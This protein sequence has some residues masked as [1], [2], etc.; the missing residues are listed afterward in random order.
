MFPGGTTS[1]GAWDAT[2]EFW[3]RWSSTLTYS[4]LWR[5]AVVR[6]ALAM[7]MVVFAP[8]GAPSRRRR[9]PRCRRSSAGLAIGTTV[10]AG[11]ATRRSRIEALLNLGCLA[12][13]RA[14]FWWFMHATRLTRPRIRVFH[15]LDGGGRAPERPF[16]AGRLPWLAAGARRQRRRKPAA[17][18]C[19]QHSPR[20]GMVVRRRR[21]GTGPGHG[22]RARRR[23]R[24]RLR[25]LAAAGPWDMEVRVA[26]SQ[27]I[28]SKVMSWVVLDRALRLTDA[29]Y[30]SRR[31][32][33]R[34]RS[35]A[36]AIRS[37][38]DAHGWSNDAH[39]TSGAQARV[40]S[41]RHC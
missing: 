23:R 32:A 3:T 30:L 33:A 25:R 29:G 38:I 8:S 14:F 4:G 13:A 17:A 2:A 22:A 36:D 31:T 40:I 16:P 37:F 41:T 5:D 6:S 18:R 10:T 7:K 11:S 27:F 20:C 24:S 19:V 1:S 15:R 21:R 39:T 34:W 12:E 26:P 35:E 9:R 28:H